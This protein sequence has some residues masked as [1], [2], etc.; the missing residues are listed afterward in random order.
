[1]TTVTEFRRLLAQGHRITDIDNDDIPCEVRAIVADWSNETIRAWRHS[2]PKGFD[3]LTL[4]DGEWYWLH[5]YK[6]GR[7]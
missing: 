4:A 1:M 2:S 3:V 7:K 6:K 5:Y